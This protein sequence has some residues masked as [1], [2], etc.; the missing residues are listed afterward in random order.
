MGGVARRPAFYF[1]AGRGMSKLMAVGFQC[2]P[3]GALVAGP[4]IHTKRRDRLQP[5]RA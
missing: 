5:S 3:M 1:T 4:G 2:G